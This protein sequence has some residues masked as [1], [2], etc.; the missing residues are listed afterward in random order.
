MESTRFKLEY[1]SEN[2]NLEKVYCYYVR[3]SAAVND[4]S[5]IH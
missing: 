2:V 3:P 1:Y 5:W 4:D